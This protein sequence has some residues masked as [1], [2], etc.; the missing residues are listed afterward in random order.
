MDYKASKY[1]VAI[2]CFTYNHSKYILDALNGFVMQQTNF[3]YVI[4][5]VDDASTDGEQ[6]IIRNYISK[7][8]N[9]TDTNVAYEKETN[10][11]HITYAQHVTNLN[12]YIVALYLKE[13]H[14]SQRKR[15][16]PYLSYWRDNCKYEAL[17]EGD[18]YWIDPLKLQKQV[19]FME[20]NP[21]YS[22]CFHNAI[23]LYERLEVKD[24]IS[25]FNYFKENQQI[26]VE[27]MIEDWYIPTASLLYR[28]DSLD[29]DSIPR[30]HSGDYTLELAL[31]SVGKV[32]YIDK[33]MS[34]YRLN[35]GGVSNNISANKW[36]NQMCEL[37]DWYDYYTSNCYMDYINKRKKEVYKFAKYCIL[38]QKCIL[39]PFLLMPFYTC[40]RMCNKIGI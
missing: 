9:V 34:V 5:I 37:L 4:L 12:C 35:N 6:E 28:C 39:F 19:D 2:Q 22:M 24:R 14:Y 31:A 1:L 13:N 3:P 26:M 36:A 21:D 15:K 29:Y 32:Y 30:F 38:K 10:Y 25:S 18:D 16:L 8:F 23:K 7:Q 33:Y 27:Q 20:N 11:A 17:C 40:K